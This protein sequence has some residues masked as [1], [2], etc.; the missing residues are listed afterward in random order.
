MVAW[1]LV[2]AGPDIDDLFAYFK[3]A[4]RCSRDTAVTSSHGEWST[5]LEIRFD[6]LA[7]GLQ[8]LCIV[9]CARRPKALCKATDRLQCIR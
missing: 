7:I 3:P 2:E 9:V 1:A 8:K 5:E 4:I 6:Q